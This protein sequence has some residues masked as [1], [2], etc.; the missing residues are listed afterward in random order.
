MKYVY[1][2]YEFSIMTNLKN[3]I[4]IG[5]VDDHRLFRQSLNLLLS[6]NFIISFEAENGKDMIRALRNLPKSKLP[7]IMLVD[8]NMP[9]MDG[10]ETVK[11]LKENYPKIKIAVLTMFDNEATVYK[12]ISLGAD[13]YLTKDSHQEELVKALNTILSK[14]S[15]YPESV[16]SHI[17][18]ALKNKN[19][20]LKPTSIV[21]ILRSLSERESE[22]IKLSCTDMTYSDIAKALSISIGSVEALR[23]SVFN[24]L[25]IKTRVGLAVLATKNNFI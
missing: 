22:F 9:I 19:I 10:Y 5:L 7:A 11:W 4:K 15:Y 6:K 21:E 23:I 1:I 25:N 18:S 16:T 17:V 2:W 13:A 14:G 3:K 24:K 20:N 12:M 8:I